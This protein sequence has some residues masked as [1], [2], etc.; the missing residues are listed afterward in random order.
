LIEIG[1][2]NFAL[3]QNRPNPFNPTTSI[4]F[5][6]GLDGPTRLEVFDAEGRAVATLVDAVLTPGTYSV[7]WD[8]SDQ[9]SGLYYYRLTS[10][11]WSRT[12]VMSL[13]K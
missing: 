2:A 11:T 8:A 13:V 5:S 12:G 6:L 1:T 4:S 3:D 10:G 9:P 7:T